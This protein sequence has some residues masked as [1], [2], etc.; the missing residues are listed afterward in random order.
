MAH[1]NPLHRHR[2]PPW[3]KPKERTLNRPE[4]AFPPERF[5]IGIAGEIISEWWAISFRN[6]GRFGSESANQL[7]RT[8]GITLKSAWFLSH[9]IR[10][11][12][13]E[14]KM[15]CPLGGQNKVVEADETYV[16]GK[17]K[18]RKNYVPPKE[19]VLSLVERGGKVRSQHV[20]DVS[21]KTLKDAM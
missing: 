13:G 16:G 18:N 12:T 4:E 6:A 19:A 11:A 9:R 15:R 14:G 7:H 20:A 3:Q 5:Q 10:E 21:G 17:A 1:R 8:L 2:D